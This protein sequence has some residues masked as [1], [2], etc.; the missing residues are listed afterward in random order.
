LYD[1]TVVKILYSLDHIYSLV[2]DLLIFNKHK[3]KENL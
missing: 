3:P 2:I 1:W